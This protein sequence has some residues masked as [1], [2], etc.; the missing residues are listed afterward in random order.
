MATVAE[1]IQVS[2]SRTL[3]LA[4]AEGRVVLYGIDWPGYEKILDAVGR[5]SDFS[6]L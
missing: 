1:P 3:P 5:T 6:H 4:G 2:P